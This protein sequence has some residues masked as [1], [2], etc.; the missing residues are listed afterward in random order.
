MTP[1]PPSPKKK[2]INRTIKY[3][4]D[5]GT[6]RAA[7]ISRLFKQKQTTQFFV[8]F[9][10]YKKTKEMRPDARLTDK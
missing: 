1:S 10:H 8:F 7:K 3:C 2:Y 5:P 4:I 9:I 6:K